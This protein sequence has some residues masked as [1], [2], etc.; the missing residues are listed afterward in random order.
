M[1]ELEERCDKEE[2]KFERFCDAAEDCRNGRGD[3][4]CRCFLRFSGFAHI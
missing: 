4:K 3:E 1:Q 2:R